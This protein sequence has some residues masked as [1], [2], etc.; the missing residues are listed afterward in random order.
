MEKYLAEVSNVCVVG[1]IRLS[2]SIPSN[3]LMCMV[4]PYR[5]PDSAS[6]IFLQI[7]NPYGISRRSHPSNPS[8]PSNPINRIN[9]PV[10]PV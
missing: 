6:T 7:D 4:H 8:N 9:P 2:S 1:F 10:Y 5:M 3:V